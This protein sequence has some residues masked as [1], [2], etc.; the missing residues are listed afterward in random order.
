[1]NRKF[2][3]ASLPP[4]AGLT[5]DIGTKR[6]ANKPSYAYPWHGEAIPVR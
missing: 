1:V 4:G 6:F 5:L 2:F 3:Q